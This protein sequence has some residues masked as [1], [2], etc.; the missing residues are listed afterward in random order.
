MS[1]IMLSYLLITNAFYT[2]EYQILL[3]KLDS[4]IRCHANNPFQIVSDRRSQ[5]TEI[6]GEKSHRAV[7][8]DHVSLFA[9][10]TAL[11]LWNQTI[12]T[13]VE[14]VKAKFTDVHT[15]GVNH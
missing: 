10:D 8:K 11:Y 7:Y 2:I 9:N 6:I 13:L 3:H 15:R 14:S 1:A 12:T 4:G 5:F